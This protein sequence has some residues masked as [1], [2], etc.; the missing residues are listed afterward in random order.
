MSLWDIHYNALYASPIAV[1][2]ELTIACGDVPMALRVIDKTAPAALGF[3]GVD[4]LDIKPSA[5]VRATDLADTD[6]ATLRNA[7]IA[8]SGRTWTI[9]SHEIFPAPTGESKGEIRL[10][11]SEE[12]E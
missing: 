10:I 11:L 1:D 9:R 12:M 6:L 3:K 8:F 5:M 7:T 2:A 4:V